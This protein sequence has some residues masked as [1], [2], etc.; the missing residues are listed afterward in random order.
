MPRKEFRP[1][2]IPSLVEVVIPHPYLDHCQDQRPDRWQW[3]PRQQSQLELNQTEK[4]IRTRGSINSTRTSSSTRTSYSNST[5]ISTSI[6]ISTRAST[7][8]SIKTRAKD[9]I[10][11][12]LRGLSITTTTANT[13][14]SSSSFTSLRFST[15]NTNLGTA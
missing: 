5:S 13:K 2:S 8:H 3:S 1:P 7:R 15:P 10:Y 14:I 9:S 11:D 12:S 4:R 6:S